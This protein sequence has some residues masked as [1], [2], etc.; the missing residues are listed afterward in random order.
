MVI[1]PEVAKCFFICAAVILT[2]W[3]VCWATRRKSSSS[4]SYERF[5]KDEGEAI[6]GD[7]T[8]GVDSPE[9]WKWGYPKGK[10]GK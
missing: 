7:D 2:A 3:A 9:E 4:H 1:E 10:E 6:A 5:S 8:R